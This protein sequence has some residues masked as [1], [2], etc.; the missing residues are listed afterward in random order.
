MCNVEQIQKMLKNAS[1]E[2]IELIGRMMADKN[3]SNRNNRKTEEFANKIL[4]KENSKKNTYINILHSK[5]VNGLI[6][7]PTQVGKSAATREF[8]ETCFQ[9]NTPVIVSTDNKT[10]QQEQLYHRIERD[11]SGADV[12]MMKVTDRTFDIDLKNCIENNIKRFVI[13]CL[14]NASQIDKLIEQLCAKYTRYNQMKNIKKIAII[15][16][17]ADTVA[18]DQDTENISIK[19]A[20]SHRKWLELRELI[21]NNM[22]GIDLKRI[23]VTATPEN[24]VMLYDIECPDVMELE[25]PVTYTGY[26]KIQHI[27]MNDDLQVTKLLR[28]EVQRIKGD[29]THEAILYCIDRKIVEGHDKI[30]NDLAE[31]MKCV[32]NTYNGNGITVYMR[33]KRLVKKFERCLEENDIVYTK[34]GKY[35]QMKHVTIRKFYSM[36]KKIGE[37]CVITIGKDLICRGI[38]YVGEDE[39]KPITATVMFYK[40]GV[41]MHAV[42]ITQTIGRITGCAMPELP[43]KL[44]APQDV[45]DTYIRYNKN[46]EK[47]ISEM[48]NA[49]EKKT[50]KVIEELVF[51]KFR[52]NV[53]R[54]KLNLKMKMIEDIHE[55]IDTESHIDGVELRKLREWMKA[56]NNTV[57][58]R[59]VKYLYNLSGET[60]TEE[61]KDGMGYD[62]SMKEFKD[63]ID[64]GRSEKAGYGKLWINKDGNVKLNEKIR[65][66][67]D[68]L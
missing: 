36:V 57:V 28:K 50:K 33:T 49:G 32:V 68:T 44:Y 42:G 14:D 24:C 20:S 2:E 13:F 37:K 39:I 29:E 47:Y 12:R 11:L 30:L 34:D 7:A 52:R 5:S 26:E 48:K 27:A 15:H 17:E 61:F 22:G 4:V 3:V 43:R 31:T 65:N 16:D 64:G 66:Y 58:S 59:M 56:E 18:K 6:Y 25:V 9:H 40:P 67:I 53:D 51:E 8:I 41:S 46:Q 21:N 38:S 60:T 35:F 10:D 62:R 55:H 1:E 23:F 63:N 19:Q 54:A 45:Y